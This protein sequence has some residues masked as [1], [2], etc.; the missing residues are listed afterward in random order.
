MN[1]VQT[2][3]QIQLKV[4]R[5]ILE[6]IFITNKCSQWKTLH[7]IKAD[8][9]E[10]PDNKNIGELFSKYELF[11]LL[12]A[13]LGCNPSPK[14]ITQYP[15][16]TASLPPSPFLSN[17]PRPT[18]TPLQF[19]LHHVFHRFPYFFLPHWTI[20]HNYWIYQTICQAKQIK[21]TIKL[22]TN[23]NTLLVKH[24]TYRKVQSLRTLFSF[25]VR[26]SSQQQVYLQHKVSWIL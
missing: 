2:P 1:Y 14:Q 7:T 24:A 16:P 19:N 6:K 26:Q 8:V 25:R 18:E 12:Q 3:A 4:L 21:Y 22:Y 23:H 20:R 15:I 11:P 10:L 5:K 9:F 17:S 13:N